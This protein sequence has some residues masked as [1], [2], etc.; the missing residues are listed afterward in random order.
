MSAFESGSGGGHV[1]GGG[2][3]QRSEQRRVESTERRLPAGD[4][5]EVVEDRLGA[6]P[7]GVV[8]PLLVR[9]GAVQFGAGTGHGQGDQRGQQRLHRAESHATLAQDARGG[10]GFDP[11]GGEVGR[12]Q[13]PV[14]GARGQVLV[15]D[16]VDV[17]GQEREEFA[18]RDVVL[19]LGDQDR[20]QGAV[21]AEDLG[22]GRGRVVVEPEELGVGAPVVQPGREV[23]PAR[24]GLTGARSRISG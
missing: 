19:G 11:R 16:Q 3:G 23:R 14:R 9:R 8:P 2:G 5:R 24:R 12:L 7:S 21:G 18:E 1:G 15:G 10:G 4:H 13:K 22:V 17:V 6:V 20:D